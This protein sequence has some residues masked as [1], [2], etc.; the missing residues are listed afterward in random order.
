[1]KPRRAAALALVGWYLFFATAA[2]TQ[3]N[4]IPASGIKGIA[5]CP[6]TFG[7][8]PAGD[9]TSRCGRIVDAETGKDIGEVTCHMLTAGFSVALPPGKY[10]VYLQAG[11]ETRTATVI[12]EENKWTDVEPWSKVC[13]PLPGPVA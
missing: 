13:R 8:P 11:D 2:G 1:M 7:N 10:I 5:G 9:P 6:P 4:P 3:D 12:V